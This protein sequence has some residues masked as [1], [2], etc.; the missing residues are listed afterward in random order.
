[1]LRVLLASLVVLSAFVPLRAETLVVFLD[2]EPTVSIAIKEELAKSVQPAGLTLDLRDYA[3][4]TSGESFERLMVVKFHG[5]C[6]SADAP[7]STAG[8][9]ASTQVQGDRI[10]PFADV[11]CDRVVST[12]AGSLLS[13]PASRRGLLVTRALARVLAH[14]I[15]HYVSQ[16]QTHA[17]EGLAKSCVRAQDLI[18]E[19]FGFDNDAVGRMRE[20]EAEETGR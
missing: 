20:T 19:R 9:L 3:T 7:V 13:Q 6:A 12:M 10:L 2:A 5:R 16:D 14:E 11:Y 1:M 4:R 18:A 17:R 8:P 15:F